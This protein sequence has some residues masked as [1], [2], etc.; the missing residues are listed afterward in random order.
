MPFK[1]GIT[2]TEISTGA[3][4]LTA[5]STAILGLVATAP[6]ADADTFPLDRPVLVT[7]IE[8]A[9]GKAG[10]AGT[11]A[12]SLRAIADQTRPVL[13]V[14]RVAEGADDAATASNVIGTTTAE[15]TK[16]GM[17]ALLAA[18]AQLGVKPKILGTPGLETQAVTA[19]LSVI[20]KQLRGFVYARAL[21][22]TIT[23]AT[24]YRANF[25]ERELMLLMPDFLAWDTAA[26]ANVTSYAAARAMGLRALIDEQTGPHKTLSNV[27]VSGEVGLTQDIH[28]D[29]EDMASDAGVLNAAQVTALIRSD[30]GFR[31]W[32]NRTCADDPLFVFES[33]VRVAQLLADTV[34][35]GMVWAMDKDLTPS[36]AR[37]IVETVNGFFLDLKTS[38]V[39]LGAKA[40][41]DETDNPVDSLKAGKLR[42]DYDYA[43][44]PPLEDLG[45][46]QRI[47]DSYFAD[48]ASQL[49][50]AG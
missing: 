21:G 43:V 38:G 13:V 48:F 10:L 5:V 24:A 18:Q 2:L 35:R 30:S 40:W 32:G 17:Q 11:L 15:G 28:W 12:R 19:A 26:N 46:N 45:F 6:D 27:A 41:F 49:S 42:I 22:A 7:D 16:T 25:S 44:P 29:I 36:L 47:T 9:I 50:Q 14:V 8:T 31:F 37:D 33:T 3:R 1:H 39:I 34:A 23:E 20:A 4:T